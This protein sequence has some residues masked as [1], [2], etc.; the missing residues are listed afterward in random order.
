M[1][2]TLECNSFPVTLSVSW[3][4][5]QNVSQ[6]GIN[7]T[8]IIASMTPYIVTGF[9]S[10]YKKLLFQ[11]SES[12]VGYYWC[13]ITD[14]GVDV[15][16]SGIVPV[17]SNESLPQCPNPYETYPLNPHIE[18]AIQASTFIV[19]HSGLP[20]DCT[21]PPSP[22]PIL[23]PTTHN[24][25]QTSPVLSI[26][27]LQL[28]TTISPTSVDEFPVTVMSKS[29]SSIAEFP[30]TVTSKSPSSIA[31]FYISVTQT[32][33]QALVSCHSS[34]QPLISDNSL[35]WVLAIA[36]LGV[37]LVIAV[38]MLVFFIIINCKQ[39]KTIALLRTQTLGEIFCQ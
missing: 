17:C 15:R 9:I 22:S 29:A 14:A 11:V 4:W 26:T 37:A 27:V 7:G 23:G 21:V 32:V 34:N 6:A 31:E 28:E 39:N 12:T 38:S 35:P 19:S 10:G 3:F 2:I 25:F 1:D 33:S 8:Q 16:P 18:C 36:G 30:V 13:E 20:T 24:S 5:T